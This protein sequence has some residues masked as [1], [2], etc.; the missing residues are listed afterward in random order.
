M[1]RTLIALILVL[2]TSGP[3]L[4]RTIVLKT[5]LQDSPPKGIHKGARI[6][7]ICH[8]I[9]AELN[10]RLEKEGIRIEYLDRELAFLPWKRSQQFLETGRLDL[11]A[12]MARTPERERKYQFSRVPLYTV[13]SILATRTGS[14]EIEGGLAVLAGRYV[15]AVR[16]TRTAR[17]LARVPDIHLTLADSPFMAHAAGRTGRPGVLP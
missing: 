14:P 16:G 15:I 4:A 5:S 8:D 9:F 2:L 11:V 1:R 12:G 7:G 17:L 13:R 10:R 3:G 6:G